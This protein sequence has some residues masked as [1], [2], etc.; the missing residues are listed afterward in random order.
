MSISSILA[1]KAINVDHIAVAVPDLQQSIVF[2]R[3]VLGFEVLETRTTAGRRTAMESAVLKAGPITLVLVQGTNE[4]SQVSQYIAHHGAG[5]QHIAIGVEDLPEVVE[6]LKAAGV[7]FVTKTVI[8]GDGIRQAFTARDPGS[9]MMYELIER[10]RP[11]GRF[12]D[13]SVQQLFEQ[14]EASDA[15]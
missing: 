3:D 12:T 5:V 1:D 15:F 2:Y 6:S 13:A 10:Q 8:Q 4:D 11:D 14:M 9:G 7:E